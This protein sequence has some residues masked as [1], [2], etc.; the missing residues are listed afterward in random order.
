MF[1]LLLLLWFWFGRRRGFYMQKEKNERRT[2]YLSLG[3]SLKIDSV[4]GLGTSTGGDSLFRNLF[5][6]HFF[7]SKGWLRVFFFGS[8]GEWRREKKEGGD[9]FSDENFPKPGL[10]SRVNFDRLC[11]HLTTMLRVPRYRRR[12]LEP[13]VPAAVVL[14]P[15]VRKC[16]LV[17]PSSWLVRFQWTNIQL[18]ICT[19]REPSPSPWV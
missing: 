12:G 14:V 18:Q 5:L 10:C 11:F 2:K 9:F 7:S 16:T 8:L 15:Y 1:T 17:E 13:S 3:T 4:L 6:F 19:Q